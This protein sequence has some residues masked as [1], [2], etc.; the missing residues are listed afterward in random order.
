M[1]WSTSWVR[2][3]AGPSTVA[4][5]PSCW[6]EGTESTDARMITRD[7]APTTL[8]T[9]TRSAPKRAANLTMLSWPMSAERVIPAALQAASTAP[10]STARATVSSARRVDSIS[11]MPSRR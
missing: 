5:S 8:P 3:V 10:A 7:G 11:T 1:S 9:T 2:F 4:S 6:P